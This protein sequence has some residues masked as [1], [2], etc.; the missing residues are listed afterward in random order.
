MMQER[1]GATIQASSRFSPPSRAAPPEVILGYA[2][3]E[4]CRF[5]DDKVMRLLTKDNGHIVREEWY[6]HK[7][8][9]DLL[10]ECRKLVRQHRGA[11]EAVAQALL[12]RETLSGWQID[13]II[14]QASG[15][16]H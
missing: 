14:A 7:V 15:T 10:R 6:A 4:G 3:E 2:T 12:E 8:R 9:D 11:I 1:G 13:Q 16:V 5:D